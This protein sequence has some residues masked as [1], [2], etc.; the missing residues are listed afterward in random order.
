MRLNNFILKIHSTYRKPQLFFYCC[1]S[2]MVIIFSKV[3]TESELV[4]MVFWMLKICFRDDFLLWDPERKISFPGAGILFMKVM[5]LKYKK[6]S[7]KHRISIMTMWLQP[8]WLCLLCKRE[9]VG[10]SKWTIILTDYSA[11]IE[12][13]FIFVSDFIPNL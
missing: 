9:K 10:H 13:T 6:E 5:N 4:I 1:S 3:A 12:N 11:F 2:V 8:C 7:G